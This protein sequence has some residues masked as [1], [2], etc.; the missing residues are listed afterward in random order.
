M[1]ESFFKM[2]AVCP[3]CGNVFE[4]S[5]G[6]ITGGMGISIVATLF[7]IIVA[8]VIIGVNPSIPL[9]PAMLIMGLV[10]IVFP[11]VFYPISRGI[12]A[13]VLYITGDNDEP[14]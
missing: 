1:F 3:V 6:E 13:G 14:D 7:I 12:W 9:V 8:G 5:S 4:R 10:A 2:R 11:I